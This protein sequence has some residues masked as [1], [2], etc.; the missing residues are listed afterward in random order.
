MPN[1][2]DMDYVSILRNMDCVSTGR[3]MD[4]IPT[5]HNIHP[6]KTPIYYYQN[7]SKYFKN[8]TFYSSQNELSKKFKNNGSVTTEPS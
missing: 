7:H 2:R 6:H 4:Y 3:D 1:G 8:S 5:L